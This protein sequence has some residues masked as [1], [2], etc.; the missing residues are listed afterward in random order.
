MN[1]NIQCEKT[2]YASAAY[3]QLKKRKVS[4][5]Y[6]LQHLASLIID[7]V[8]TPPPLPPQ[9]DSNTP[10]EENGAYTTS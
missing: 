6:K 7:N 8:L 10:V 2:R 9:F 5:S 3:L 4:I 1:R